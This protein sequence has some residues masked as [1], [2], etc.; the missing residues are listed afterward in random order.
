MH[1]DGVNIV[2][3]TKMHIAQLLLSETDH[4]KIETATEKLKEYKWDT[5]KIPA[6]VETFWEPWTILSGIR[7]MS[8]SSGRRLLLYIHYKNCD[9][10]DRGNYQGI[11]L[12]ST[13]NKILSN[14]ILSRLIPYVGKV[15]WGL[16]LWVSTTNHSFHICQ[17]LEKKLGTM[18]QN[19]NCLQTSRNPIDWSGGNCE[20]H[21]HRVSYIHETTEAN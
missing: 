12:L 1:V 3:L 2:R 8:L 21:S 4:F 19:S 17:R 7:K 10:T 16:L 13:S 18:G 5:D 6:G 15:I 20:R 14:T 9:K 11:S